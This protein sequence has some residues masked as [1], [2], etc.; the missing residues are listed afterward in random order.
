MFVQKIMQ[1][2]SE[3]QEKI[4]DEVEKLEK[5]LKKLRN[6]H[7]LIENITKL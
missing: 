2:N 6:Y 1:L 3:V 5:E 4:V 7:E